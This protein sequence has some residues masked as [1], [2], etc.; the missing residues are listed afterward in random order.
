MTHDDEP[1]KP[2]RD[3]AQTL[4]ST[5]LRSAA[6]DR[7]APGVQRRAL[8]QVL[9]RRQPTLRRRVGVVA[10]VALAAGVALLVRTQARAPTLKAE[11][12][13][14][15]AS[16]RTVPPPPSAS[17]VPISPLAP[18]TPP[19]VGSGTD[20]LIDDFEDGDSR[21]R[22]SDRRA[23]YWVVFN[24]GTAKQEPR[25]GSAFPASRIPGG[26]GG[27]H[28]GLHTIGGKFSK[29]GAALSVEL[30]PRRCYDA[31][32]YA[33]ISFWARGKAQLRVAV[34]MTQVIA[35][36]FGGSC[37]DGCYD[38]HGAE[39]PLSAEWQQYQVR[40]DELTQRGSGTALPFDPRSLFALEFGVPAG[41]PP[42]DFWID[43]VAFIAR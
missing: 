23:G 16:T 38:T 5:L 41:R 24:D 10:A 30:S 34:K 32:A 7:P 6:D 2:L 17:V 20:T 27:G 31:S 12:P 11:P 13:A 39:R 21:L 8:L 35:E 9:A 40:W 43:D 42:F 15:T 4:E 25:L 33:G 3:E 37:I 29:W 28:F 36:E 18:C 19:G 1:L 14:M 22:V 26:R